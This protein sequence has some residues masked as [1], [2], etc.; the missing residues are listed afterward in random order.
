MKT[1][2]VVLTVI[3]AIAGVVCF[4]S[5]HPIWGAIILGVAIALWMPK[6]GGGR[7]SSGSGLSL[8]KK[9]WWLNHH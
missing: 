2:K 6:N 4:C 9:W 8:K 1:F 3:L 7:S 5:E